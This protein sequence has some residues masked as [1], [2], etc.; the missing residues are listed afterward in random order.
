M[1][2]Q[3]GKMDPTPSWKRI[4]SISELCGNSVDIDQYKI[5]TN[6]ILMKQVADFCGKLIDAGVV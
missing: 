4:A 2:G 5:K 6:K 3:F 1:S